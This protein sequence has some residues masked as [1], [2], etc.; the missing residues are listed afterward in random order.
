MQ[1]PLCNSHLSQFISPKFYRCHTCF[2]LIKDQ[3]YRLS[4][5]EEL[6]RYQLHTHDINDIGYIEFSS[7]ITNY[8]FLH[9]ISTQ[10]GLDYGSGPSSAISD[11]L[12]KNNYNIV[13]YDPFFCANEQVLEDQYDYIISCEV[14]E[15]FYNPRLELDG[16][17][18]LLHNNGKLLIM[19][20][21]YNNK[22]TFDSWF[23]PRDPT[24][25]FIYTARTIEYI[26][27][28]WNFEIEVL[29]DRFICLKKI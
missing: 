20:L 1:C 14:F 5:E 8:V 13:Q 18:R 19:T 25:V 11:I 26:A 2:A 29:Q 6:A 3:I 16:L 12:Q 4:K 9:L 23:Y 24:H 10:K 21:L 22:I 15:H 7:P 28:E 17:H 27:R